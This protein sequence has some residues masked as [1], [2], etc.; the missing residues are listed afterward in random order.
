MDPMA[1]AQRDVEQIRS[2]LSR[3][4]RS[5]RKQPWAK[6]RPWRPGTHVWLEDELVIV[7]LHDLSISLGRKTVERVIGQRLSS[8]AVCFV[9]GQGSHSVGPGQMGGATA[10]IL[11]RACADRPAWSF[12]PDGPG[13]F[14]LITDPSLAP[15]IATTS[16]PRGFWILIALFGAALLFA[17]VHNAMQG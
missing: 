12:R 5:A 1:R 9:T 15:R 6:E 11:S 4:E 7:D 10:S 8:G 16:L 3:V 13:R 2:R 14:V 17:I